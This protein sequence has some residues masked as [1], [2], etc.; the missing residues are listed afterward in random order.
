MSAPS[1]SPL[2]RL[3]SA[4]TAFRTLRRI[5]LLDGRYMLSAVRAARRHGP[6]PAL[7]AAAGA[8]KCPNEIAVIDD[9]G[10]L[11][12][13]QL[14]DRA[15]S[16]ANGLR[17][18]GLEAG[19]QV[20]ILCRNHAGFLEASYACGLL[21]ADVCYLNT[22]FAGPQLRDVAE[23]ENLTAILFDE[24]FEEIMTVL[25]DSCVRIQVWHDGDVA[26]PTLDTLAR[27]YAPSSLPRPPRPGR[28]TILT[29]GTTGTPKG[30]QRASNT[31][32]A[33]SGIGLLERLPVR[34]G[35][36]MLIAAPMFHAWGLAQMGIGG[37]FVNTLILQRR[38]EPESVLEA[39]EQHRAE[40]LVVVP[41][42]LQRILALGPEVIS[43]YDT[44]SLQGTLSSGSALPGELALRW[45]D[46]LGDNL[47]N[48]Y[49]STEVAQASIATPEDLRAAPG[50]AGRVPRGTVVKI[51]DD[52]GR[53]VPLG[54]T[55]RIFV[56]KLQ[57]VRGL[58]RRW[59]EGDDRRIDVDR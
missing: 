26:G 57:P 39:I 48:F 51:L 5:G 17:D 54:E 58:Y 44:S 4:R 32:D 45:M 37:I 21:G 12:F 9:R 22:G 3:D 30:A 16:I 50:T 6:S 49:G 34:V 40:L 28:G 29:S 19:S 24:E 13:Q 35:A 36:R 2:S 47:Y 33:E 42:M 38:F 46:A 18:L 41:V 20:G 7:G 1:S 23:R 14:Y 53:E 15:I 11:T 8:I 59:H 25:P 10:E 52:K 56:G 55:G 27:S 31:A 43:R